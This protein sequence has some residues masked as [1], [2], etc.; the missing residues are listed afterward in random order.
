MPCQRWNISI[1][2]V[3][4]IVIPYPSQKELRFLVGLGDAVFVEGRDAEEV[5]RLTRT[6]ETKLKRTNIDQGPK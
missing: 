5:E 3:V 1:G 2:V 6:T 4:Q